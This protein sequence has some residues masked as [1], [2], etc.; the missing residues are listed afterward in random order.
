MIKINYQFRNNYMI[1]NKKKKNLLI[2]DE[3][4]AVNH[5]YILILSI[6]NKYMIKI[7]MI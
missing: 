2:L 6:L 4:V 5:L 1:N 3:N 7:M